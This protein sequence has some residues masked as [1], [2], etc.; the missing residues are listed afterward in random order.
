MTIL[1]EALRWIFIACCSLV[2]LASAWVMSMGLRPGQG[3]DSPTGA[4]GW[5]WAVI[6]YVLL[7]SGLLP[8]IV[9]VVWALRVHSLKFFGQGALIVVGLLTFHYFLFSVAA[10]SDRGYPWV[11]AG[12]IVLFGL[13]MWFLLKTRVT[14][15]G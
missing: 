6:K 15:L 13:A 12:E 14:V 9:A 1:I 11:Q 2:F 4:L 7:G 3:P 8:L 10:H 5:T